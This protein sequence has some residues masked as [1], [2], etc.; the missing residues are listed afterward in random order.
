MYL[1]GY[2]QG[3]DIALMVI[4]QSNLVLG[5]CI[6]ISGMP[7]FGTVLYPEQFS[8]QKF[9]MVHGDKDDVVDIEIAKKKYIEKGFFTNEFTSFM[10][11]E[12]KGH[13]PKALY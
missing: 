10:I 13:Y 7:R 6:F 2:S 4:M 5:G 1:G 8:L 11:A 9:L 3:C 12:G